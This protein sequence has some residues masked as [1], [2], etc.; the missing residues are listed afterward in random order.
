MPFYKSFVY[1]IP[2]S[3]NN[4]T[5]PSYNYKRSD[6]MYITFFCATALATTK[7]GMQLPVSEIHYTTGTPVTF[8]LGF[9]LAF[10]GRINE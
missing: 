7:T 4:I 10:Y 8:R 2:L 6:A 9:A 1:P 5:N 3:T